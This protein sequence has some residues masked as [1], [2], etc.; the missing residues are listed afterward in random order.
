MAQKLRKLLRKR[1][2]PKDRAFSETS[3]H[4]RTKAVENLC[5]EAQCPLGSELDQHS[6]QTPV[7]ARKMNWQIGDRVFL[8]SAEQFAAI[9]EA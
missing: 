7:D 5:G 8:L 4:P 2:L 6:S 9:E 1:R 3:A